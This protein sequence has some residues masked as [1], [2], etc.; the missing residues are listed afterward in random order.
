MSNDYHDYVIKDGRFIGK[1]E[2]M[3]RSCDDPWNQMD[4]VEKSY[5]KQC[6]IASIA[7]I[8]PNN[9]LEVGCGLGYF[10]AYLNKIYPNIRF[11][12][13][14]ISETAIKK[15]R[16]AFSDIEFISENAINLSRVLA[17]AEI[18][19]GGYDVIIFSEIMWY[20]LDILK[21]M[22]EMLNRSFSSK[23]ILINQTFYNGGQE[24]GK[25]FFTNPEEMID[26]LGLNCVLSV[27]EKVEKK[28]AGY[29]SHT[30]FKIGERL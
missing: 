25:D 22:L 5:S 3:Y 19:F 24:Y 23:H 21:P 1:F 15:A 26:F 27:T 29:A 13:M 20:I 30:W 10:T 7:R 6:T 18:S 9:V 8:A 28:D 12:G 2:E 14:D 11:V 17:E 4:D 16:E